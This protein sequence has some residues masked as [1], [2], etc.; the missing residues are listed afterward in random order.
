MNDT[1]A[2]RTAIEMEKDSLYKYLE[3]AKGTKDVSGKNMFI[4]LSMDEFS[5]MELL[6]RALETSQKRRGG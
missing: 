1:E 4:R 2:L 5:H 6:Y 3:F